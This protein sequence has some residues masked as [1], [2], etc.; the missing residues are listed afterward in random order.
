M[1]LA[2]LD[3]KVRHNPTHIY[4]FRHFDY[5]YPQV[6]Y[7]VL[8]DSTV[9]TRKVFPSLGKCLQERQGTLDLRNKTFMC[10]QHNIQIVLC[11]LLEPVVRVQT[12]AI[13]M[14]N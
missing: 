1:A 6:Q 14:A 13:D 7:K 5:D 2:Q 8:Q 10:T 3:R 9:N 12:K 4:N 11:Y